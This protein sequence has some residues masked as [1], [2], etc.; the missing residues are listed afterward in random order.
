M[1]VSHA[2]CSQVL[3]SKVDMVQE[4]IEPSYIACCFSTLTS[5]CSGFDF[6]SGRGSRAIRGDKYHSDFLVVKVLV[7][8]CCLKKSLGSFK[9]QPD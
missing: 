8:F 4:P 7:D 2:D 5:H 3:I 9:K 6:Q 1:Y